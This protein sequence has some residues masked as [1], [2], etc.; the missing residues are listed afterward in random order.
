MC[1]DILFVSHLFTLTYR[2]NSL[3][4][5]AR[6][7][8]VNGVLPLDGGVVWMRQNKTWRKTEKPREEGRIKGG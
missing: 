7:Y 4:L 8:S 3:L 2:V 5:L 6:T 1:Q